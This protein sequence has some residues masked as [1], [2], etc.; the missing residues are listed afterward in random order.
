MFRRRRALDD[1]TAELQSHLEH[2]IE[3]LRELGLSE[4]EARAAA[5]R[6]FGSVTQSRE[7]F[8]EAHRW[9]WLDR[10]GQDVRYALRMLRKAPGFTLVAVLTLAIGIGATTAIFGV[11]DATLLRP[12]PYPHPEQL[13]SVEDDLVGIGSHDVGMSQPEWRDLEGSGIF[14]HISPAWFDENNLTGA[15]EPA[16]VRLT[17]VAPNYFAVLGV[18]PELGR[19]FPPQDRSPSFTGEV[20]ISDAM[21]R[22]GFGSDPGI[23]EK[24]IRLD[25]DLYHIVG[26]MPPDVRGVG[27]TFEERNIDV[28]AA[29]SFYGPPMLDHP[30]RN[31]RNLPNTVGRLKAGLT[32]DEAQR[33]VDALVASLHAAYPSDYPAESAWSIRLVPLRD[34]VVGSVRQ[35]LLL[36][37]GA[38]GLVLTIGCANIASLL[39]ARAGARGRELAVRQ[40]LGA[41]RRRL[42]RQ[43]LTESVVLSSL[44]GAA[45]LLVLLAA[46]RLLLQLIPDTLPHLNEIAVNWRVLAFAMVSTAVCGAAFGLAPVLDARHLDVVSALKS[47]SRGSTG[48]RERGRA[49]GLLVVTE[50]ALSLVLLVAAGL[51]VRSLWS[52][53]N[54]PLGFSPQGV[55]TIRTRLP[56]PNDVTIDKYRTIQQEASFLR[57]LVDRLHHLPGVDQAAIGSS[58]AIPLDHAHRDLN[59]FPMLIEGRGTDATQAPLVNGVV[60]TPEYFHLLGLPLLR[61]R[62]FTE[63][64]D[65][66]T[67]AVAVINDAMARTFWP[68]TNPIGQRV[69]LSRAAATGWT[70]IVG[71]IANARTE[72][73]GD[74]GSPEIYASAYQKSSKHLAIVLS[75]WL[76]P[77]SAADKVRQQV[78][79]VD[80]TLP[81]FGA[82]LLTDTVSE[83]LAARRFS[84][85]IVGLFAAVALLLATIG[86]YGVISHSVSE[87][88]REIGIRLALGAEPRSIL[89]LV[90]QQ[91]WRVITVGTAIGLA[92]SVVVSRLMAGVL[93]GVSSIDWLTFGGV[94]L[95]LVA[96]AL[97]ACYIPARHALRIEPMIALKGE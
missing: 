82:R 67:T 1:F 30:L 32:I 2:E 7:R 79:L 43:L 18:T 23:L 93:Y 5:Y 58:N 24:S 77:A 68:D 10:L 33:R 76:D 59:L 60:V 21:W 20:I 37:F 25:T 47:E 41:G 44:G 90:L 28:W 34:T 91:G 96:V 87:R 50:F 94:T 9:L 70:T 89:R 27:R 8:Y 56:Y 51:L 45:G 55:L 62:L 6:R 73:L 85:E 78:H 4:D 72:S 36:L 65:A 54:A 38:V 86:I 29:T 17:S 49:R 46:R 61:G 88:A 14:E 83:S 40:S 92:G 52:L 16:R 66:A 26:V 42:M 48:S 11:V 81:V 31:V 53:V 84:M 12:L 39:L 74:A 19:L 95:V 69:K 22:Q 71:V 63:H 75:T 80:A 57:E 35:A 15:L 64:D 97:I 13:V 3:R